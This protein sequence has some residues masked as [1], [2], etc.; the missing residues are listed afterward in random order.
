[1][2][3]RT[4]YQTTPLTGIS[5]RPAYM[6]GLIGLF[7][8]AAIGFTKLVSSDAIAS[9]HE[10]NHDQEATKP[11]TA[12]P[13]LSK[14]SKDN[15]DTGDLNIAKSVGASVIG[16]GRTPL[17]A[18]ALRVA[19][20][21]DRE[22]F[23]A[24]IQASTDS[25][26]NSP[27][28][29]SVAIVHNGLRIDNMQPLVAGNTRN[30]QTQNNAAFKASGLPA[31]VAAYLAERTMDDEAGN[32]ILVGVLD[33]NSSKTNRR[34]GRMTADIAKRAM[35]TEV[36]NINVRL[37]SLRV[38]KVPGKRPGTTREILTTSNTSTDIHDPHRT[39]VP[40][41]TI[42]HGYNMRNMAKVNNANATPPGQNKVFHQT[43]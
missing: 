18:E 38:I 36:D 10:H 8:F 29:N 2:T 21:S 26:V 42:Y 9:P 24:E 27:R 40:D 28:N 7:F 43:R 32:Q 31:D 34:L 11:D 23:Q 5:N 12:K 20:G 33:R 13:T 19:Y 39:N 41:G 1:M 22:Y 35:T 14:A 15:R 6:L 37:G 25:F 30:N 17:T 4:L 3:T 16:I